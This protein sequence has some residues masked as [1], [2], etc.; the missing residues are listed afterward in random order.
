MDGV[1]KKKPTRTLSILFCMFSSNLN[2][3]FVNLA[4][5]KKKSLIVWGISCFP[6]ILLLE[7]N[8]K[9]VSAAFLNAATSNPRK[10]VLPARF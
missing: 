1:S 2:I 10:P 7:V 9:R 8:P 3:P 6:S 5:T 4:R